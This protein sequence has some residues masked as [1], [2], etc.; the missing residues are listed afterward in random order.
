MLW[1]Q[2]INNSN[3]SLLNTLKD[4][5]INQIPAAGFDKPDF[6]F[7]WLPG[8][9]YSG[10]GQANGIPGDA[11]FGNTEATRYQR[12]FAHEVGHLIGQSHNNTLI[13]TVGIDV[14][15]HLWNSQSIAQVMPTSKKDVMWA[16]QLTSSA[17][18]A[19]TTYNKFLTNAAAQ[20]TGDND[21]DA[22]GAGGANNAPG[23]MLRICGEID[24]AT[25]QV[26][27]SPVFQ[28][29]LE[30]PTANDPDGDVRFELLDQAGGLLAAIGVRTNT[31]LESCNGAEMVPS[32]PFYM[33]APMS[34]ARSAVAGVRMVDVATGAVLAERCRPPRPRASRTLWSRRWATD[35][36]PTSRAVSLAKSPS[37]APFACRGTRSTTTATP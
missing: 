6:I 32:S 31:N 22:G 18:V 1:T 21:G 19:A 23:T 15:H 34:I 27:L 20:C 26:S 7:G 33:F 24:H 3:N 4:I 36:N 14:E 16:G 17:W 10:N 37:S 11:A 9:P 35:P 2:N 13:N 5:R 25:R 30:L 29:P 8:N 12:T 28:V